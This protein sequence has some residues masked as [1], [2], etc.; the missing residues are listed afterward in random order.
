M[1]NLRRLFF[2]TKKYIMI[3][4][5]KVGKLNNFKIIEPIS[6]QHICLGP[7]RSVKKFVKNFGP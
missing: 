1:R 2:I 3:Y 7:L 6:G 4:V 5:L